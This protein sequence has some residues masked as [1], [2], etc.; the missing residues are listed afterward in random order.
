[1]II[2][3]IVNLNG[4][5]GNQMFQ[6]AL[7]RSVSLRRGYSLKLDI[8]SYLNYEQHQGFELQRIFNS[9]SEIATELDIRKVLHWQHLPAFRGILSK[10]SMKCFRCENFI[11]EPYF[12]YW[13]KTENLP[14]DCYLMGYWQSEKYFVDFSDQIRKDFTFKLPLSLLNFDIAENILD[15][16]NAVS[17]HVRR[18]DYAINPKINETHGLCTLEY[19]SAAIS[20]V[21]ERVVSPHFFVFSD[22][23][24]WVK[25]NIKI[26]FPHHFVDKNFGSE[27][28]ND[29]RLMSM[30]KHHIIANSTFSWWGAWL[31]SSVSKIVVAPRRWFL[32]QTDVSDLF[33]KNWA[34]L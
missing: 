18:G 31:N 29:M 26:D 30:C 21:A 17:L 7:G 5:L 27:S 33:P 2:M 19:Y 9:G 23:I 3:V 8:S 16:E 34:V 22:D 11:V 28:Y 15:C 13:K 6:Y 24:P 14:S 20:Y 25:E 10:E 12:Q 32:N 1:M 4:G